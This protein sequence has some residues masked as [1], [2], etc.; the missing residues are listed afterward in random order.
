MLRI[1]SIALALCSACFSQGRGN[2]APPNF[3]AP[4]EGDYIVKD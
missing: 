3:P 2:G 4:K 1:I